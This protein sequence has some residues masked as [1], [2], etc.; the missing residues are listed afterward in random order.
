M[1]LKLPEFDRSFFRPPLAREKH[2]ESIG[3]RAILQMVIYL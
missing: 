1:I 3:A 2:R